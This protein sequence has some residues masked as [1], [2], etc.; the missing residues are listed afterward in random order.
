MKIADV[1]GFY[2]EAGGGVRR[3]VEAKFAA[4]ARAGHELTV[5]APGA[6][7]RVEPRVGGQVRW[8]ASPTMPFDS[9]YRRFAGR[10]S[11]WAA[12]EAT[13]PDLVE[14]SSP[15]ASAT[16]A[17]TWPGR[18]PRVL[19]F[20]QDVAAAYAHTALDRMISRQAIDTLAWPWWARLRR[21]SRRFGATVAGGEWL[22]ARLAA[23][24]VANAVAIPFGIE[25]GAFGPEHRDEVLRAELLAR[26]GAPPDSKLLLAVSRFHPEKRLP[27]VI[28]AFGR[29][30]AT[31]GDLALAI[32]GH[33]LAHA[34]VARAA[35][36]AGRVVLLGAIDDREAL[37]RVYAS[38]DLFVHGS[39][40]ETYGLAVAEAIASGLTAVTPDRGGAGDLARVGWSKTYRAGDA[41][42]AAHAILA[43]LNGEVDPATR[44]PPGSLNDHFAKLFALYEK[45]VTAIPPPSP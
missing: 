38:A 12:L 2:A 32:V 34:S 45:R 1:N 11:V 27:T 37:A 3:Y 29:A 15:W 21:L 28:D 23:H 4:A 42:A 5:I 10:R 20:H 35:D 18:A 39:A 26:C 41:A 19:V 40:A 43:A 33:G 14:A 7:D 30:R 13:A 24:G 6:A 17:A 8:L 31:R 22:A 25:A 44:P 9:R 16:I 36:R